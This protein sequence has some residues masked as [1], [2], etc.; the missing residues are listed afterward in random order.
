MIRLGPGPTLLGTPDT[1]LDDT[2]YKKF[3]HD[4]FGPEATR[5]IP[6]VERH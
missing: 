2:T 1:G 6:G 4:T 3:I 5:G